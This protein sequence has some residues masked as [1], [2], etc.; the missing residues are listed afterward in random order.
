MMMPG[1]GGGEFGG[2]RMGMGMGRGIMGPEGPMS[3]FGGGGGAGRSLGGGIA[4]GQRT[5]LP[6]EVDD[7]LLRFFDYTVQPG[8]E[9]QYRVMLYIADPNN[10][11]P[12][13]SG[14]LDPAVVDRRIKEIQ[15]ARASNRDAPWSR[16]AEKWSD[17]SPVVA[18]PLGGTVHVAEA[19][20][21]SAKTAN[22]E[23]SI[24]MFAESFDIE[25]ADGSAIHVAQEME[26]RRGSVVNF[27]GK[28]VLFTGDN[29]RWIDK[30]DSYALH[31]GLTVLDVD[32]GDD[33][34]KKMT[35]PSRVLLM[36]GAGQLTVRDEMDDSTDVKYL[37]FVFSDKPR[38][39]APVPGAEFGPGGP[40]GMR[41]PRGR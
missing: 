2:P 12:L 1:R 21:P 38:K 5:E 3:E 36:D 7:L 40:P 22:D 41:G 23:P 35:A 39:Q 24:T 15:K 4:S 32:G 20:T 8:K 30:K 34:G 17:P 6:R 11:I 16:P 31:T 33:L 18:I 28:N 25:P 13:K 19:K 10:A 37:R 14:I 27:N 9:Y 26:L 29:D